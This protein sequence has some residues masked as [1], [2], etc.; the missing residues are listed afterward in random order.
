MTVA[1]VSGVLRQRLPE[2][3]RY[4]DEQTG[5]D[6]AGGVA[7]QVFLKAGGFLFS[8]GRPLDVAGFS[9]QQGMLFAQRDGSSVAANKSAQDDTNENQAHAR[10]VQDVAAHEN[11][12]IIR[13]HGSGESRDRI[14]HAY[15]AV[16][17]FVNQVGAEVHVG[18]IGRRA[19]EHG[20]GL[21]R[22]LAGALTRELVRGRHDAARAR[23]ALTENHVANL[24][25]GP[26]VFGKGFAAVHHEIRPEA[27]HRHGLALVFLDPVVEVGERGLADDEKRIGI[28]KG[29]EIAGTGGGFENGAGKFPSEA[30]KVAGK[31]QKIT[32][33]GGNVRTAILGL[34]TLAFP[35]ADGAQPGGWI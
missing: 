7:R 21:E 2:K 13:K 4:N 30:D 33:P 23:T 1:G 12:E 32:E 15:G 27:V 28:G 35:N 18:G 20:Q 16:L 6:A 11:L 8:L 17:G 5:N 22:F 9:Q 31:T 19:A 29:D 25:P 3:R 24:H 26:G 34:Q 14:S 10:R